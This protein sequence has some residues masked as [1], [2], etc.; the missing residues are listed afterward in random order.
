MVSR[1]TAWTVAIVAMLTMTVSYMDRTTFAVLAQSVTDELDISETQYGWLQSAFSI[2][3]LVATPLSGWW[4]DRIGARRGLVVSILLWTTVAA[5]HALVPGFGI[6]FALRIALGLTEGPSFPGAAQTMQR[7]LPAHERARGFGVLFTGSSIG[8]MIAPPLASYLFRV[9]DSWR[10][11]FV[12]SA[13]VGI[14][15]LPLW[16]AVTSPRDV[17]TQMDTT[18]ADPAPR[19]NVFHELGDLLQNRNMIRAL[20]AILAVAPITG[21]MLAWGGKYLARAFDVHPK[22]V[23]GYLWLPPLIFD[24][25]TI[26]SGDL[27]SRQKRAPGAPPR[28]I[29]SVGVVL[30]MS[31]AFVPFVETPWQGVALA[32]VAMGGGGIVYTMVLSD[33]LS[34]V[35][36]GKVSFA[37][38]T[39]AAAQSLALIVTS[40]LIGASVDA[41]QTFDVAT[42]ALA[43]FAIPGALYWLL[44]HPVVSYDAARS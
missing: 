18:S 5:L 41:Y 9:T 19:R 26:A 20:A 44:R 17:R 14:A 38:G 2:A 25:A 37:S 35:P 40:P 39:V 4:I 27:A 42:V 10:V 13:L 23:G 7:I 30:A 6:L 8:A 34:R 24:I 43:A 36:A 12:G 33:L 3:Y 29:F 16:I 22:S 31:I 32:G 1:P 15:W 28:L 21:F 11:A